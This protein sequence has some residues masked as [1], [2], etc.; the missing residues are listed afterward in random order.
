MSINLDKF[1]SSLD[2]KG[3]PQRLLNLSELNFPQLL[4][5]AHHFNIGIH[6]IRA[7]IIV[8]INE[9][10]EKELQQKEELKIANQDT[11]ELLKNDIKSLSSEE[12]IV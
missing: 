10:I 9:L 11:I 5:V 1:I 6:K 7:K 3:S 2:F 8:E 4:S 12:D